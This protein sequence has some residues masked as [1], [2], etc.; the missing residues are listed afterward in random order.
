MKTK[1]LYSTLLSTFL[2]FTGC[3]KEDNTQRMSGPEATLL[4]N[5]PTPSVGS[6]EDEIKEVRVVSFVPRA[7][8]NA[9]GWME[10]NGGRKAL[11]SSQIT[12]A[13]RTGVRDIY[14]FAN[15]TAVDGL[16]DQLNDMRSLSDL[17]AIRVPYNASMT[18]PFL[19]SSVHPNLSIQEQGN[20]SIE[21]SLVRTV[22]RIRLN[23]V[24][25][26]G[27][28]DPSGLDDELVID[29]VSVENLP[30]YSYLIGKK[31]HDNTRV[32]SPM[33]E[34]DVLKNTSTDHNTYMSQTLL[35]YVPEFLNPYN[36]HG[37][38]A[39]IFI[40]GYL[41]KYPWVRLYYKIPFGDGMGGGMGANPHTD[42]SIT[43]NTDY[44]IRAL[45]NSYGLDNV[46]I[47]A[48]VRDWDLVQSPSEVGGYFELLG[49]FHENGT[50][51]ADYGNILTAG[52]KIMIR[53]KSS[54]DKGWTAYL[55]DRD[56]VKLSEQFWQGPAHSESFVEFTIPPL[57][58]SLDHD[59]YT[60]QIPHPTIASKSIKLNF[61]QADG[62]ILHADGLYSRIGKYGLQVAKR[63]NL[64]P[65]ADNVA[66]EYDLYKSWST[67]NIFIG[68]KNGSHG[69]GKE[70]MDIVMSLDIE[71]YPAFN[72]CRKLGAGW[73]LPSMSE[74]QLFTKN[75]GLMSDPFKT[76]SQG[77]STYWTSTESNFENA[78]IMPKE[79][80]DDHAVYYV[81]K[82]RQYGLR[83]VRYL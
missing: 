62:M 45:I 74:F 37:D 29:G 55:Y 69:G 3:V 56:G 17:E 70:S 79:Y 47:Y 61:V 27:H 28:G 13:L 82:E 6:G 64:L 81:A 22:S 19:S 7:A 39:Y 26:W 10:V 36:Y 68:A 72:E 31:Y 77:G 38:Y 25:T 83:C 2:L 40:S 9:A 5:I 49:V 75:Q 76:S 11:E 44:K 46:T 78:I 63:G 32:S 50:P 24:Y 51:L 41:S 30:E 58:S 52:E 4:L 53:C 67:E 33:L 34:G 42:Y 80:N 1:L 60:V 71:K 66:A 48:D 16:S 20:P 54:G 43:R 18:P 12:Q 23:I 35:M 8:D 57:K 59:E 73:Y 65:R 14:V 15:E 21:A